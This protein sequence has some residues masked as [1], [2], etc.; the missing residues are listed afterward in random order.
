MNEKLG[1]EPGFFAL[2]LDEL[3]AAWRATRCSRYRG[4]WSLPCFPVWYFRIFVSAQPNRADYCRRWFW[5]ILLC[6]KHRPAFANP[7]EIA[8][9]EHR[10]P[11]GPA[12]FVTDFASISRLFWTLLPRDGEYTYP[13][14]SR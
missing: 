8:R 7:S 10:P 2:L 14:N 12:G 11:L 4:Q 3:P 5:R 6:W 9:R 13:A 1:L